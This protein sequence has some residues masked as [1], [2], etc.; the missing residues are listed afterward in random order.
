MVEEVSSIKQKTDGNRR[1]EKRENWKGDDTQKDRKT[2][3]G[4]NVDAC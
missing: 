2:W 1:N 4:G 3:E